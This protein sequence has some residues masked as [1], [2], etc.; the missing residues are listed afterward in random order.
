MS[1]NR[2]PKRG[3]VTTQSHHGVTWVDAENPNAE[4]FAELET[5]YNLHPLHLKESVQKVQHTQV[6]RESN[7]LFLVMHYPVL[8]P[9]DSKIT[10]SQVGVFLGKDFLVTVHADT[11]L[12]MQ[13]LFAECQHGEDQAKKNFGQ[14]SAYLLYVLIRRLLDSISTM[15]EMVEDELDNIEGLV[16]ENSTSDAQQISMVRQKIIRLRRLIGPKRMVLQDL[17]EQINAFTGKDMSRYYSNNV[18]LA[19]RLWEVVDEAKD[20]I[21][22]YKDADFTTSTEKTNKIL[23]ILT[24]AFTF[25]IP[26]T[27]LGTLYG[28]NILLPGGLEAGS[29]TFLG[30]YTSFEI[31]AAVSLVF[32]ASMYVYF[33]RKKWF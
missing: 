23:M 11:T 1:D 9:G 7:Y 28:M 32:A 13:S 2:A 12:F 17:T 8:V 19:N 33:K 15:T 26:V 10:A 22:I 27:V 30:H 6:E 20:T 16:F 14:S 5:K 24:L 25:T 29:W 3:R 4:V 18:K 31:I 21:E